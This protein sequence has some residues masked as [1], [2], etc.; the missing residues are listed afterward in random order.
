MSVAG[1]AGFPN[2][3]VN[4]QV[5]VAGGSL[6]E[7]GAGGAEILYVSEDKRLMA[8]PFAV[9]PAGVTTGAPQ[10]LF[11]VA[12]LIDVENLLSPTSNA[13]VP[14]SHGQRI[15]AAISAPDPDAPPFT[16]IVNWAALLD[17]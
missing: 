12:N 11:H 16:V 1:V 9:G 17:R 4:R 3:D 15:L 5:S 7:W 10:P 6:P 14:A 2:G 8:V 13:Y